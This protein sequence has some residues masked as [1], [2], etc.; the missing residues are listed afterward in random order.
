MV[1][2]ELIITNIGYNYGP[3]VI[4]GFLFTINCMFIFSLNR[5]INENS[6]IKKENIRLKKRL[7]N[8]K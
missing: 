7:K 3:W 4:T 5:R 8:G 1:T 6:K 2:T